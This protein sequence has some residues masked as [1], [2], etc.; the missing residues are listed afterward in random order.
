MLSV[1]F[2]ELKSNLKP[3]LF[4]CI[5][6]LV[7][8]SVGYLEYSG[9][10][11]SDESIGAVFELM[12]KIV[13]VMFGAGTLSL[14]SPEGYYACMFLW[15]SVIAF[16]HAILL[17]SNIISKEERDKTSEFLFI[18]PIKR[19]S[20]ITAKLIAGICNI[21][22]LAFVAWLTTVLFFLP[23]VT[24]TNLFKEVTLS[25]VGM[26]FTGLIFFFIGLFISSVCKDYKK[27]NVFAA[28]LVVVS[29]FLSV[30]IE[31][32][33]E[34][35]FL[36]ILTPFRY[37]HVVDVIQNGFNLGYFL[38]AFAMIVIFGYFT[39]SLWKK[40]DLQN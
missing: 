5:G 29:Y 40:R 11:N 12:P 9:F 6:M 39:Y 24:E 16:V 37:F 17:G 22:L 20:I 27:S 35:N 13:M 10:V 26:L 2:R 3:L 25:M 32:S 18:K 15:L 21:V 36:N 1:C 34:I 4:W 38:L 33:G 23:L 31:M 19:S 8:G 7:M 28:I 14:D 30:I